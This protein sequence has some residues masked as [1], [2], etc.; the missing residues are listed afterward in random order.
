[1]GIPESSNQEKG[2]ACYTSL[3][4]GGEYHTHR[5]LNAHLVEQRNKRCLSVLKTAHMRKD[6]RFSPCTHVCVLEKANCPMQS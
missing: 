3:A 5:T 6:T 4:V 2:V 1:M